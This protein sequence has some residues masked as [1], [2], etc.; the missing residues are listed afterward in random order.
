MRI[1]IH[2]KPFENDLVKGVEK[3]FTLLKE[4]DID[5]IISESF[6]PFIS[7]IGNCKDRPTYSNPS[8][9]GDIDFMFTLGGDGTILEAVTH[10]GEKETP[11]VG[12]NM[13]RLGFLATIGL[14]Q[15]SY[16][17]DQIKNKKYIIDRRALLRLNDD[18]NLFKG[19]P[20]ALNDFSIVKK[21]TSSMIVVNAY[22]DDAFLN[23]YWADGLVVSTPTGSTGYSLS[24]GG[25]LVMPHSNNFIITPI[26]PHNLNVRPMV[27]DDQSTMSFTI[28]ARGDNV[29]IALDSRSVTIPTST[30][31]TLRKEKFSACLV[32]FEGYH[33]FD[34]L[35]Q[36][37]YWGQ[38]IRN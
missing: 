3:M 9:L 21:D 1:A 5:F 13:G 33:P 30:E 38:D 29:L 6:H 24:C 12:I 28:N 37:L 22:V 23:A 14:D 7:E 18:N 25:P 32:K 11:I 36:K 15:I 27:I 35:R 2:G 31:L 34:T 17:L 8:E 26:S 19:T 10:I 16:A 4:H 20:F